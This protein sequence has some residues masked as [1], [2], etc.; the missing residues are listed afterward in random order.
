MFEGC[1]KLIT[2]IKHWLTFTPPPPLLLA[3]LGDM[4]ATDSISNIPKVTSLP[5]GKSI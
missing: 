4:M 2:T 1:Y 5:F 3:L